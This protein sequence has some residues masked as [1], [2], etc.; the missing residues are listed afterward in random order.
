[1]PTLSAHGPDPLHSVELL[2]PCFQTAQTVT[3]ASPGLLVLLPFPSCRLQAGANG[4]HLGRRV[5]EHRAG[6]LVA[7]GGV[8]HRAVH[9][10]V[11]VRQQRRLHPS[12]H[13]PARY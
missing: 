11:C 12:R 13:T 3:P 10:L 9:R 8:V 1:M 5:L 4:A 7:I 2:L 6:V